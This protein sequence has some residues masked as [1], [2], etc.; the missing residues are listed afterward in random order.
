MR[1]IFLLFSV[2]IRGEIKKPAAYNQPISLKSK[3]DCQKTPFIVF[4]KN[5]KNELKSV[6]W[7]ILSTI[8]G[9][10]KELNFEHFSII[11]QINPIKS[12][13]KVEKAIY[14]VDTS[15]V[16]TSYTTI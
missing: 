1:G 16:Y 3:M 11:L 12:F 14:T 15:K 7:L 9:D 2:Y 5:I 10:K 6:S 8:Q 4:L 13:K